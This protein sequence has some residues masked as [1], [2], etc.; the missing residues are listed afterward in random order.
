MSYDDERQKRIAMMCM[1]A[2]GTACLLAGLAIFGSIL[3]HRL[4]N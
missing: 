1:A 3:Y 4:N 2:F